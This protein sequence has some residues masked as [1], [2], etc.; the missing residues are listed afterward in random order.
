[1]KRRKKVMTLR[2]SLGA[3][4]EFLSICWNNNTSMTTEG[5]LDHSE[6]IFA[7]QQALLTSKVTTADGDDLSEILDQVSEDHQRRALYFALASRVAGGESMRKL[8]R[9]ID[10]NTSLDLV[11][12]QL[13]ATAREEEDDPS[14]EAYA[15][16]LEDVGWMLVRAGIIT[17]K[18]VKRQGV[19][20]AVRDRFEPLPTVAKKGAL[21]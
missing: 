20:F 18:E 16:Q 1:M 8:L 15:E 11:G 21:R 13:P 14:A 6:H 7:V 12:W 5:C 3:V 2:Q 9:E 10:F 19:R 17:E 4:T